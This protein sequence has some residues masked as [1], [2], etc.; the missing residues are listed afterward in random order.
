[1]IVW[2]LLWAALFVGTT[3]SKSMFDEPVSWGRIVMCSLLIVCA[4]IIYLVRGDDE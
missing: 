3:D 4:V 1:M 2:V